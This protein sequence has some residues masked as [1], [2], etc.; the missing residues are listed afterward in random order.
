M[1]CNTYSNLRNKTGGT[2]IDP[3]ALQIVIQALYSYSVAIDSKRTIKLYAN[4]FDNLDKWTN[5][6]MYKNYPSLFKEK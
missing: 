5:S 1:Y 2:T 4:K 6:W 3:I